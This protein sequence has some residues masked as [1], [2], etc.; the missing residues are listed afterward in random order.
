[1]SA[2]MSDLIANQAVYNTAYLAAHDYVERALLNAGPTRYCVCVDLGELV[3]GWGAEGWALA[4]ELLWEP[5]R[6]A[7]EAAVFKVHG[8]SAHVN[9]GPAPKPMPKSKVA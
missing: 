6:E 1:Q 3:P 5:A 4:H 9:R 7:A 8:P 2:V